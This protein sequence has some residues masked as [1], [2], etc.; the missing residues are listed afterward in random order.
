MGFLAGFGLLAAGLLGAFGWARLRKKTAQI[1]K[2]I[3]LGAPKGRLREYI[4]S[5]VH[6]SDIPKAHAPIFTKTL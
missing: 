5:L 6:D 1:D 4:G 3:P 2:M